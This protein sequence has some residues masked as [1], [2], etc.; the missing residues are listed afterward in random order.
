MMGRDRIALF[1]L[2]GAIMTACSSGSPTSA[3]KTIGVSIQ[4]RESQFYLDMESGLRTEA[5]KY[6]YT[7]EIVDANRDNARQQSQVEDF[8]SKHVDAIVLTPYDSEAIG[9]AIAEANR[10]GVPVF[11]ADTA[12]TSRLGEVVAHV[13]SDNFQGGYEAGTLMCAAV[14]NSGAVAILDFP[15]VTSVQDRVSGFRAALNKKCS[16]ASIVADLDSG[17]QRAKAADDTSDILQSHP[18]VKGIFGINDDVA[19]GALVAIE[20]AN[21]RGRVSVIG[22]DATAE[23]RTAI[24]NGE[25]YGDIVQHPD[26]IGTLTIDAVHSYFSNKKLQSVIRVPVDP[27]TKP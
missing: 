13:S 14:N 11:T 18:D 22:F 12:S 1:G 24:G 6:S 7:L 19:L 5:A 26:Q 3:T 17:G 20:A 23:A 16:R 2:L 9:S 4:N 8:L 21:H 10:A 25:L 27:I 15:R